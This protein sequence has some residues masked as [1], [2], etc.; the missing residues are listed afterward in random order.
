MRLNHGDGIGEYCKCI[1]NF[2]RNACDLHLHTLDDMKLLLKNC[3]SVP[4]LNLVFG[5]LK[6]ILYA[7]NMAATKNKTRRCLIKLMLHNND[8]HT[9]KQRHLDLQNI[10]PISKVKT[11]KSKK[12]KKKDI[13]MSC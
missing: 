10:E 3:I 6:K 8:I 2:V 5:R 1:F 12:R 11:K 13:E 9:R 4:S 7:V